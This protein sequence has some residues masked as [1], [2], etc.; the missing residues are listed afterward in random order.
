MSAGQ[1]PPDPLRGGGRGP[2]RLPRP[3]R[4][5]RGLAERAEAARVSRLPTIVAVATSFPPGSFPALATVPD[6][7]AVRGRARCAGDQ[8]LSSASPRRPARRGPRL[9]PAGRR[10]RRR[11]GRAARVRRRHPARSGPD[12]LR[13]SEPPPLELRESRPWT[14]EPRPGGR[15]SS[16]SASLRARSVPP[17]KRPAGVGMEGHR[18]TAETPLARLSPTNENGGPDRCTPP[19]RGSRARRRDREQGEGA[20]I[21]GPRSR[22]GSSTPA[23][24]ISENDCGS[25]HVR[26]TASASTRPVV[27]ADRPA[28]RVARAAGP[29]AAGPRRTRGS[30]SGRRAP[31]ARCL[32]STFMPPR[33]A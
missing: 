15:R 31:C 22:P 19:G 9:R 5:L 13:R 11:R 26:M 8:R 29:L 17:R 27:E 32:A 2:R 23:L 33:T 21:V 3:G 18:G 16:R 24:I 12:R 10:R 30:S 28:A 20:V 6:L 7:R 14:T 25:G 1:A 4:R